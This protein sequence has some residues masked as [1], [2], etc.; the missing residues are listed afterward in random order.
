MSDD[1]LMTISTTADV[2]IA[3]I[4]LLWLINAIANMNQILQMFMEL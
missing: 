2:A 3:G 4:A 1:L